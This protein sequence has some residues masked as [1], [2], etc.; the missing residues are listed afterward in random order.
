MYERILVTGSTGFLG[1]HL[2]PRLKS[3]FPKAEII[4]VGRRDADLLI[5]SPSKSNAPSAALFV[6]N[7]T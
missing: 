3:A 2:M 4:G 7:P 6:L 5:P 1:H